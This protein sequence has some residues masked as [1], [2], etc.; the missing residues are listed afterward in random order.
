MRESENKKYKQFFFLFVCDRHH[1]RQKIF[2]SEKE[3]KTEQ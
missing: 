3:E 1:I 2:E